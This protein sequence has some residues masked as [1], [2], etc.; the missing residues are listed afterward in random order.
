[1]VYL[2]YT[3]PCLDSNS[4]ELVAGDVVHTASLPWLFVASREYKVGHGDDQPSRWVVTDGVES[5]DARD[6]ARISFCNK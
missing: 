1:M 6:C 2:V 3:P 4:N 5:A